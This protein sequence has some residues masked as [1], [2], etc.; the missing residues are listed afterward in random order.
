MVTTYRKQLF[1]VALDQYGYVT[2][3]DAHE[4]G[5][6]VVE[7]GKLGHRGQ[8]QRVAYGI[9]RIPEIPVSPLDSYMLATLWTDRRGALSHDTMLDLYQLCDANPTRTHLTVPPGYRPRRRGGHNYAVHHAELGEDQLGWFEGI[10]AVTP[11]AAIEQ[12]IEGE[13]ATHLIRQAVES[14][15]NTGFLTHNEHS[16]LTER[17]KETR[18]V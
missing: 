17:L 7:L 15:R 8:I 18:G 4:L 6:P 12:A 11:L 5:V 13:T 16:M 10:R 2:T 9:Y 14:A 1:E 3:R